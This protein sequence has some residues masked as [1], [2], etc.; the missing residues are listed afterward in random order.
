MKHTKR[1]I[2]ISLLAAVALP[3]LGCA[4]GETHN[5]YLFHIYC[6]DEFRQRADRI[7]LDNWKAYLGLPADDYFYFDAE[8][9]GEVARQKGD[10]LMADYVSQLNRYLEC[11]RIKEREQYEW[12]YPTREERLASTVKLNSIRT[13]AKN[14][15][16]S[17]L[18]SQ[19]AL[20][21]MRCNMMLGQH[22]AN[23][24]FWEQ[25]A[26]KY[27]DTIYKEM[28]LNIY[29][30]ALLKT[31]QGDRAG[32]I[33]AA[34][35][36]WQSLMTQYYKRR[37]YAAI[38]QEYLRDPQ[39]PVLPFLL[40]DFVNNAQEAADH[41]GFGKLFVRDIQQHEAEQMIQLAAQAAREKKTQHPAMWMSAKARLE[42]MFG[43]RVQA[44]AD[45]KK[46]V[47]ME[48]TDH[49]TAC[50]R[51]LQLYIT[52][53]QS[54]FTAQTDDYVAAELQWLSEK[55][56]DDGIYH[57]AMD[58]IVH[59]ALYP[60]YAEAGRTETALA[61]L[62]SVHTYWYEETLDTMRVERLLSFVDYAKRPATTA[63]DGYLKQ[64]LTIDQTS[65]NDLIGTKYL[66]LC[67]WKEALPWLEKVPLS[68]YQERG[69]APYAALRSTAIEPWITRQWLKDASFDD[70]KLLRANPKV[71]FA[72]EMMA[73][74]K[75]LARLR[76]QKRQQ[77]C[78]DL[79]VRYAQAHFTG[80]CWFLMRNGKSVLD[81]LRPNETDLAARA[82]QL[83]AEASQS[84]DVSLKE[85][86]LFALSYIYLYDEPWWEYKWNRLLSENERVAR[87]QTAHYQAWKALYQLEQANAANTSDYV[88][89]CDEYI[90]FRK[91]M[92]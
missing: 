24:A 50:A 70:G 49:M 16:N 34:Q 78:Y 86:A 65:M 9:I 71:T 53:Q 22:A 83:L 45:I 74:E 72:R 61:L 14:K 51:V 64:Q 62:N 18:R 10:Q 33:F 7:S 42:Y 32:Q 76:G 13:F 56:A 41:D 4:W 91:Q 46:A 55:A 19:Y 80:D 20:L 48:G 39:S 66:R 69:Y 37:S 89:R 21:Y 60:R 26:S 17:R 90:Q 3:A 23:V 67:Q 5:Y 31:G 75:D 15:L 47:G 25:T 77:L 35:G 36:D 57:G 40:Q 68:Y 92:Q 6:N 79:A 63:L 81:E 52:A 11:V 1:F 43:S 58:R 2:I 87:P 30:G 59:Q 12:D 29:A 27:I 84:S 8:R 54:P 28:M 73:M 38:R 82:R 85:R 88:Q 44:L